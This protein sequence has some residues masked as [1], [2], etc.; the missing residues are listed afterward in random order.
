M[1]R[2]WNLLCLGCA[3]LTLCVTPLQGEESGGS[4]RQRRPVTVADA[5]EMTQ[6]ADRNYSAGGSSAGKV[7]ILSP[8]GRRF[9]VVLKKG[10]LV[11]NTNQF[12]ILLFDTKAALQGSKPQALLTMSSSSNREGI[13]NVQW[14]VDN[15]T[16]V[17][18]GENPG[19][20]PQIYSLNIK[21]R[22]LRKLTN[23]HTPIVAYG[24]SRSGDRIVFEAHPPSVKKIDTP[25]ARRSGIVISG[26]Y[27]DNI[28]TEDCGTER[29]DRS[30]QL[31][32]QG[33]DGVASHIETVDFLSDWEPLS[34]APNGRFAL[35]SVYLKNVP[36]EWAQYQDEIL[37]RY[38]LEKGKIS[39]YSNVRQFML[40]DTRQ[41][42]L[43]PLIDAPLSLN[44]TG[45]VWVNGGQSVV[46]SGSYLPLDVTNPEE[47]KERARLPFV[48][49]VSLPSRQYMTITSRALTVQ[50]WHS[51]TGAL[52]LQGLEK[53]SPA[54][55]AY[56][57]QGLVWHATTES[58]V[59]GSIPR[60]EIVLEED[61]NT[62]PHLYVWDA[63]QKRRTLLL[64]LNPQFGRLLFG[65]VEEIRWPTKAGEEVVGGLYYPPN[66]QAGTRYP[67]V[68]QTHGFDKDRFWIDGPFTSAFAAQPLAGKGIVVL[69]V[70]RSGQSLQKANVTGTPEEGPSE[71]AAYE[72]AIDEL[73]RRG[74]IDR[75]RVGIVGFSRTAFKVGYTLTHSQYHFTAATLADG[76][77]GGY[78]NYV[79][80][81]GVDSVGVNG[82]LPSG[83]DLALWLKNSP[84]FNLDKVTAPVRIEEYAYGSLLGGWEW[85]SGLSFREKPVEL[86]WIPFGTHLLVKPWERLVSQQ[87][88]VDWFDYWLQGRSDPDPAKRA[89]YQRWEAMRAQLSRTKTDPANSLDHDRSGVD[90]SKKA[91]V[92]GTDTPALVTHQ[93]GTRRSIWGEASDDCY[94]R[95]RLASCLRSL[96]W[97]PRLQ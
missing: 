23:H 11:S 81:Q 20:T 75:N 52:L 66:Y 53:G 58:K 73:D 50:Q 2:T 29:N 10:N 21:S 43:Q 60:P 69:Q 19:E 9:L 18:L 56:Q 62:P 1:N 41:K 26:G 84:G 76:F 31:Y 3:S 37:R 90:R 89:Q 47:K 17:F 36:R 55:F 35:V 5:I 14:L 72:G 27:P 94:P 70:G 86:I 48:A 33:R 87:G 61:L 25:Q 92:P 85:F 64:D 74:L 38:L 45:F 44:T 95:I 34:V 15:E 91:G 16:I 67:L 59:A 22:K 30:E 46:I 79:L 71:M 13:K 12:S 32:V 51:S 83:A 39:E 65:R 7:G 4:Q 28:L 42:K 68:I 63:A 93:R 97:L 6:W 96:A 54:S 80:F 24:I 78:V 57:K 77:E 82:G 49:E 40:L 8:D 88:N